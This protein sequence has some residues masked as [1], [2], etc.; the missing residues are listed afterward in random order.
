MG[1]I[2]DVISDDDEDVESR[3]TLKTINDRHQLLVRIKKGNF[4][5]KRTKRRKR[6]RKKRRVSERIPI[7]ARRK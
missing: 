3:P 2:Y 6:R 4:M 7:P 5:M 1:N